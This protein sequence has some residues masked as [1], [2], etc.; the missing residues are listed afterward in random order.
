MAR[1]PCNLLRESDLRPRPVAIGR[2]RNMAR[3]ARGYRD[4][5]G[6]AP[7]WQKALTARYRFFVE[8]PPLWISWGKLPSFF[9]GIF[10]YAVAHSRPSA[11]SF[12]RSFGVGCTS[13]HLACLVPD[14]QASERYI[15]GAGAYFLPY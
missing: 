9:L 12:P 5:G 6:R 1:F 2:W 14:G 10:V 11:G 4:G 3:L 13:Q 8:K 15:A 7:Y